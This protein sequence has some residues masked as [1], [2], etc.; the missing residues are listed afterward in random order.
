M[1]SEANLIS[2]QLKRDLEETEIAAFED[3][4]RAAN[5]EDV[6]SCG[7]SHEHVGSG[8]VMVA[9]RIDVLALNRVVGLGLWE[10]ATDDHIKSLVESYR[11]AGVNRFFVQV[12]PS[13]QPESLREM[14]EEKGFCH[15]NNWVKLYRNLDPPSPAKTSLQVKRVGSQEAGDFT[16]IVAPAFNW[17]EIMQPWLTRI[18]DRNNWHHYMAYD[19]DKPVATGSFYTKDSYAWIDFAATLADY[20]GKGA[21]TALAERR[22]RDAADMG[23]RL[24]VVETAEQTPEHS[25]PSYRNMVRMGFEVAYVRP[26]YIYSFS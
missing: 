3:V 21:Q 5:T 17:P 16:R 7:I 24:L 4:Y 25:A 14:L 2:G 19:G 20:R 12:H 15:H 22:I 23:C 18:I 9:S 6:D 11:S 10:P 1:M 8:S 26:N 13:A